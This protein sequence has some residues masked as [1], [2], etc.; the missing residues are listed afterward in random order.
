MADDSEGL[1]GEDL[2][3]GIEGQFSGDDRPATV[4]MVA[5]VYGSIALL[6]D[7]IISL[8]TL[9]GKIDPHLAM[10]KDS[11]DVSRAVLATTQRVAKDLQALSKPAGGDNGGE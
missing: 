3:R 2:L 6:Q 8:H 5:K 1:P 11:R 9:V 10:A 7:A 4:E